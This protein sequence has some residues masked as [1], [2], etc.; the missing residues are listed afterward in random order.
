VAFANGTVT[1]DEVAAAL[2]CGESVLRRLGI[3]RWPLHIHVSIGIAAF[4]A[5]IDEPARSP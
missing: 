1:V 3:H 5:L 4:R 2:A